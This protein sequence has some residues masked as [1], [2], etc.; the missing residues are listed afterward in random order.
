MA[1]LN[2]LFPDPCK[3]MCKGVTPILFPQK[4]NGLFQLTVDLINTIKVQ[5]ELR[6]QSNNMSS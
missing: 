5:F 1:S 6:Q 2:K 4:T 3:S